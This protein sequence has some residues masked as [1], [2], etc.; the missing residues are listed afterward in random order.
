M[1][2]S[3]EQPLY[4]SAADVPGRARDQNVRP[5]LVTIGVVVHPRFSKPIAIAHN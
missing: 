2:V 1:R 3:I 4:Q 5:T